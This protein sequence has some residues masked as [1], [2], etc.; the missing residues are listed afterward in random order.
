MVRAMD[1]AGI[2]RSVAMSITGHKSEAVYR[3]YGLFDAGMQD[4]ALASLTPDTTVVAFKK[5]GA[6]GA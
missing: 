1:R 3:Q 6:T 4:A 5:S 2:S